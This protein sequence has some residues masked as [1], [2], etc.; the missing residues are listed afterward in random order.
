MHTTIT[1]V[2][3]IPFPP[4]FPCS[5]FSHIFMF[6]ST[7]CT[8][9]LSNTTHLNFSLPRMWWSWWF[10]DCEWCDTWTVQQLQ[11]HRQWWNLYWKRTKPQVSSHPVS[12]VLHVPASN[13]VTSSPWPFSPTIPIQLLS[14]GDT[15][16]YYRDTRSSWDTGMAR[17]DISLPP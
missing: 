16:H 14:L 17:T 3:N 7:L 2:Y 6:P 11:H 9:A 12:T 10:W 8:N 1:S 13:Y 5:P 15:L 4:L